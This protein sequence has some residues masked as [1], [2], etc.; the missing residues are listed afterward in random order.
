MTPEH[1]LQNEIRNALAGGPMLFR[2][3]VGRA[4]AG[5]IVAN[6]GLRLPPGWTVL[7]DARP[8]DSGLP[9]GFADLFGVLPDGRFVAIEVK[10]PAG[11]LMPHQRRFLEAITR[12]GGVAGVA[13]SVDDARRIVGL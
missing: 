6:T 11:R 7:K 1:R 9:A 12:M 3:N 13:R 8:F 5:D 10:T 4:W 2:A